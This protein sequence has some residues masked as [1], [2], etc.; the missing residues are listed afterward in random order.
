[1][2]KLLA[3]LVVLL[4]PS[5][6][7]ASAEDHCWLISAGSATSIAAGAISTAATAMTP[8]GLTP[9][10]QTPIPSYLKIGI[11]LV[12]ANNGVTS[13]LASFTGAEA[14]AGQYRSVPE[15]TSGDCEAMTRDWNPVISGKNWYYAAI[16]WSFPYGVIT[17]TP[18]GHGAGDTAA[19]TLYGC[20]GSHGSGGGGGG[21]GVNACIPL[22]GPPTLMA[23]QTG[24]D[25]DS[26]AL[27]TG[28][29]HEIQCDTD[30]WLDFA[31]AASNAAAD[32][33]YLRAFS[34]YQFKTGGAESILHVSCLSVAVNGDCRITECN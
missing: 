9:S 1:M 2:K 12:D 11:D 26:G 13:V 15:C 17:L 7:T 28:K 10:A 8:G 27:T 19:I 30:A 20:T 32:D 14:L 16:P 25:A 31:A 24:A 33:K 22:A 4:V 23:C 21:G 34:P 29:V 5:A 6:A 18:T 3:L